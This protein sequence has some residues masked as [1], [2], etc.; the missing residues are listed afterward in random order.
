MPRIRVAVQHLRDGPVAEE[1]GGQGHLEPE[2]VAGLADV[3]DVAGV[4]GAGYVETVLVVGDGR[5]T[6]SMCVP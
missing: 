5:G 3:E 2:P 1:T 6:G 4:S